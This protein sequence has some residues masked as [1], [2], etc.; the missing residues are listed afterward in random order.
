MAILIS[1]TY[2]EGHAQRDGLRWI[3]EARE[4]DDPTLQR[5]HGRIEYGPVDVSKVDLQ[6]IMDERSVAILAEH[7]V[8]EQEKADQDAVDAK[9]LSALDGLVKAGTIT[10][11]DL[12][13]TGLPVPSEKQAAVVV[14]DIEAV[15]CPTA[16]S[17]TSRPA[18]ARTV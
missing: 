3:V 14:A 1:S 6:A 12:R 10:E 4:F 16:L 11:D 18:T 7:A 5:T 17:T 2:V 9:V 13:K 15:Q 8:R